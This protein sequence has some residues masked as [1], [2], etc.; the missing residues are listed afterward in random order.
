MTLPKIMV[1]PNGARL[2]KQDHPNLPITLP[3]LCDTARQ[4]FDSGAKGLH[5]H[6]RDRQGLHLL[7]AGQYQETL[8]ELAL[9]VP[10]MALQI[11]SEAAGVYEPD[12]QRAVILDAKPSLASVS[13]KELARE[14][15]QNVTRQF[16]ENCAA[17]GTNVQHIL[18]APEELSVLETHLS[19]IDFNN[20]D[21]QLL[22]V[23][24]RYGPNGASGPDSLTPF[25][26]AMQNR[27][28]TPDWAVCAFGIQETACLIAANGLGGKMR[29][30][31]ENSRQN[32]DGSV[33]TSNA[34]RVTEIVD[35]VG[36]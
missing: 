32:R 16:Y 18:Y 10:D 9:Q 21:M 1:A 8:V 15:D 28:I 14:P 13:I 11:T 29:V 25:L 27:G 4:C 26:T 19:D 35:L 17:N 31:F 2:S 20:P 5:V 6:I 30:G 23:L 24:G 7:D 22:F 3:E 36:I 34:E 33:A 12:A